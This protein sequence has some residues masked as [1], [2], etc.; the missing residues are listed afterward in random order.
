MDAQTAVR[1]FF[2]SMNQYY[3]ELFLQSSATTMNTEKNAG[4]EAP[5]FY[6]LYLAEE[7]S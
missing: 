2:Y 6:S 4:N 1:L 3:V 7:I 5:V